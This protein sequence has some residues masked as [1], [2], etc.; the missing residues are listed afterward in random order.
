VRKVVV[1]VAA[2]WM[3]MAAATAA[4]GAVRSD[5]PQAH[6]SS[7]HA[8][9]RGGQRPA[10]KAAGR[11][12]GGGHRSAGTAH[13]GHAK[14]N[15]R[16]GHAHATSS[17]HGGGHAATH[18][19]ARHAPA[20]TAKAHA[21]HPLAESHNGAARGKTRETAAHVPAKPATTHSAAH[22]KLMVDAPPPQPAHSSAKQSRELPPILG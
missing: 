3:V 19:K 8:G 22:R 14:S 21:A 17:Q 5:S 2:M 12:A 10:S 1:L 4:Q 18:A 20:L 16:P 7:K 9:K 15:V 11:R 6:G 13:A